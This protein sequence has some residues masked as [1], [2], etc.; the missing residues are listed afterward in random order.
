MVVTAV[1]SVLVDCW[2]N[3]TQLTPGTQLIFE[4]YPFST[5]LKCG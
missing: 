3:S 2:G 4:K 5:H 1:S